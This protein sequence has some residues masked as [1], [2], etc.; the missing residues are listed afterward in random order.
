MQENNTFSPGV[1]DGSSPLMEDNY[2]SFIGEA[3]LI[4]SKSQIMKWNL[5]ARNLCGSEPVNR[6]ISCHEL[7]CYK[8]PVISICL[9]INGIDGGRVRN[10]KTCQF[11]AWSVSMVNQ[12]E[13]QYLGG[14]SGYQRDVL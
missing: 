4:V 12:L 3:M 6:P 13:R 1:T 2:K 10:S 11:H 5:F 9:N 7:I 14:C 8:S